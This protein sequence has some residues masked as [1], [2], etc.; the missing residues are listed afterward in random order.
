MKLSDGRYI[1][2]A[3]L[4]GTQVFTACTPSDD[5]VLVGVRAVYCAVAGTLS[6]KNHADTTVSIVAVAGQV[7][8]I[9]PAKVLAATTGTYILLY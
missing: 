7:I 4:Q 1:S 8:P 5:T 2:E 9:S 3:V 6:V